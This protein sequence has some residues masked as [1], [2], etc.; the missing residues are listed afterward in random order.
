MCLI[1]LSYETHP[2]YRMVLAA[3]RDEYYSRPTAPI[4]FH[5]DLSDVLGGRDLKHH[6]MWLGITRFGRLAAITN[7]RDPGTD[8]SNA[9]SRGFLVRDFLSGKAS[10]ET[11]LEYVKSIGHRYNGFNLLVGDRFELFY[12]SNRG[13]HIKKLK[14]GI[15]GL[16]NHLMDTPW[17]KIAKGKS[18]L[19]QLLNGQ[20]NIDPE[21]IFDI[22]KDG[23]FP[24][25]S[26]L[27]DTGVDLEWERILSPL[28]ITSDIYGTR[29]S[30]IIFIERNGMVTFLERTFIPDAGVSKEEKTR[31]FIFSM[32][33]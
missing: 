4:A 24:P 13:N 3:N 28:F 16:S 33:P 20:E 29:S 25:D 12:Y 7:Y 14:P 17:P 5:D 18:D 21:D 26:M 19:G 2:K 8:I 27:P 31:E 9:P 10:P 1:L 11:Y 32:S 6:G 23:S 22:L 15:Y 30:S